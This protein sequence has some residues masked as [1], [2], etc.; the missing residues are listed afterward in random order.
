MWIYNAGELAER[1]RIYAVDAIG[2]SGKSIPGPSYGKGF[3]LTKWINELLD[4]LGIEKTDVAGVSYGCYLVQLL[5]VELPE[6]IDRAIGISGSIA[7]EGS[8][9][10]YLKMIKAFFPEALFPTDKN[11]LK[12]MSKLTG[13]NAGGL[14]S[15]PS[16]IELI[17]LQFR[18][19]NNMSMSFH[20]LRKFTVDEINNIKDDLKLLIGDM[21]FLSYYPHS[22]KMLEKTGINYEII[23]GCGHIINYEKPEEI[24]RLIMEFLL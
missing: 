4:A 19:F 8:K 1:F 16:L 3:N 12:L 5:K 21:D 6:R 15:N 17:K 22:L 13:D 18:N 2:A 10:P 11:M 20:K 24:N 14:I 9:S 7:V 23:K